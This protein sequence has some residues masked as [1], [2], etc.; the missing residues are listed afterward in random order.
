MFLDYFPFI[1]PLIFFPILIY[2]KQIS[3][4]I[5]LLD[6]P[7]K[8]K[9]HLLPIPK[10]GGIYIFV[11]CIFSIIFFLNI[12]NERLIFSFIVLV[13]GL[14]LIGF[15]DDKIEMK[16]TSR[17]ILQFAVTA[18]AISID[19][20]LNIENLKFGTL[21]KNILIYNGSNLF[22][23]F[24]IISLVN[25]INLADGKDGLVAMIFIIFL[26]YF[27][28]FIPSDLNHLI[29][30]LITS[31]ILFLFYNIKGRIFL[32]NSGSYLVGG[33]MSFITIQNYNAEPYE[34]EII[35]LIFS[36]YGLDMLRVYIERLI[37]GVH[38]FTPE[39]NHL[40]NYLFNYFSNKYFALMLYI[41]LAYAPL[42]LH[43][44][45]KNYFVLTAL[46]ISIYIL[47]LIYF[48]KDNNLS[49]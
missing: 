49:E 26:L 16:A 45:Y 25:A 5:G 48:K 20:N 44:L 21:D 40:H 29:K 41:I 27:F 11:S 30:A 43:F 37:R 17:L 6:Y 4:A 8:R 19:F 46:S 39:N 10:I 24:C 28:I 14:F 9:K 13:G 15:I 3:N 7:D 38:P 22:T 12:Y 42:S 33:L 31:S 36:F 1:I 18:I 23:I 35:F 32:G 47:T 2:H 34:I